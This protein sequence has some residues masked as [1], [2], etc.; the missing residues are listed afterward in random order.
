MRSKKPPIFVMRIELEEVEPLVWRQFRVD[1]LCTL[2]LLHLIVQ[3]VMGWNDSHLH[4]FTDGVRR[5]GPRGPDVDDDLW[6]DERRYRLYSLATEP[7][8]T[9]GYTYDFGDNWHHRL[10]VEETVER[11]RSIVHPKVIGGANACP[12]EDVGG[13]PG[14]S[15]L[16]IVLANPDLRQYQE[17][18]DWAGQRFDPARFDVEYQ[19]LSM[20]NLR[21]T[22]LPWWAR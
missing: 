14:Y 9:F 8:E 11:S 21:G 1:P 20:W 10:I 2:P 15:Q 22:K 7:G 5:F 3:H 4:C 19:N 13:P 17:M 16:K 6:I 12:P 18:R